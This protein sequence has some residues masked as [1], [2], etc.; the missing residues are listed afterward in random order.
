MIKIARTD[1]NNNPTA[2]TTEAARSL[3]LKEGVD[4]VR[5]DVF[6]DNSNLYTAK[7]LGDPIKTTVKGL[8][9][10]SSTPGVSA[11]R[12]QA[13]QLRWTHTN[14]SNEEWNS[15]D[16]AS[17]ANVVK[18][19]YQKE[20]GDGSLVVLSDF[21]NKVNLSRRKGKTDT[22]ILDYLS[23]QNA[24][25]ADK[26]QRSRA[27]G[28]NDRDITNY[29][30]QSFGG[31]MPTVPSVST[32]PTVT[33]HAPA[34]PA[35]ETFTSNVRTTKEGSTA[36]I[37]EIKQAYDKIKNVRNQY[38]VEA[39]QYDV[40]RKVVEGMFD[41]GEIDR[42]NN[43]I[44]EAAMVKG[45]KSQQESRGVLDRLSRFNN[46]M[47]ET[48]MNVPGIK[49]FK[50][51]TGAAVGGFT[52]LEAAL[53]AAVS[54]PVVNMAQG[55]KFSDKWWQSI[56]DTATK[57]TELG[58]VPMPSA[59]EFG[60]QQGESLATGAV[61]QA[62]TGGLGR[63]SP[64]LGFGAEAGMA[65]GM[66]AGGGTEIGAGI[67]E[68]SPEKIVSGGTSLAFAGMMG[69]GARGRA[70][71]A[72][73]EIGGLGK[74]VADFVSTK[75]TPEQLVSKIIQ[76][77]STTAT[78]KEQHLKVALE[79]F[80][81]TDMTGVRDYGQAKRV[82]Q[83]S[84]NKLMAAKEAYLK[85]DYRVFT[86]QELTKTV[87]K[88]PVN[89][90]EN[91]LDDLAKA[92]RAKADNNGL[93]YIDA[94]RGKLDEGTISA[95]DVER[96]AQVYGT[97]Y[98]KRSFNSATGEPLLSYTGTQFEGT[99]SGLKSTVRELF[100]ESKFLETIDHKIANNITTQKLLDKVES[101]I[102]TAESKAKA[103]DF[104]SKTVGNAAKWGVKAVDAM[105]GHATSKILREIGVN[106]IR[107]GESMS[108][109]DIQKNLKKFLTK[110]DTLNNSKGKT[111]NG[112]LERFLDM[113]VFKSRKAR[114][115]E[116]FQSTQQKLL[117]PAKTVMGKEYRGE[118]NP[119][120]YTPEQ[121]ANIVK[122]GTPERPGGLYEYQQNIKKAQQ[123]A[124]TYKYKNKITVVRH[125]TTD[126]NGDGKLR[127]WKNVPLSEQGKID[128]KKTAK[129]LKDS[130]ITKIV[131]SDLI[132]TEQ[133]AE[134]ISKDT[135]VKVELSAG[136]RPWDVGELAGEDVKKTL[137]ILKEYAIETPDKPIPGGESF[138][139]FKERFLS[140]VEKIKRANPEDRVAIVTHH[141]GDR[142][143]A[144]WETK[145]MPTDHNVDMEEFFK[146][147]IEPSAYRDVNVKP[148]K[149]FPKGSIGYNEGLTLKTFRFLEGK[150][151]I[152]KQYIEDLT[153]RGDIRQAERD[154]IRTQLGLIKG[155]TVDASQFMDAVKRELLPLKRNVQP[156]GMYEDTSLIYEL[157]GKVKDYRE[158]IYESPIKTSAGN[159][160]FGSRDVKQ[161]NYFGHTRTEDMADGKTRR[162]IEVQSDLYQRG[163][164]KKELPQKGRT[165]QELKN[166]YPN[167]FG[168]MT[169]SQ[170]EKEFGKDSNIGKEKLRKIEGVQKLQQYDNP[171]AHFRMVREEV[172]Q[173]AKDGKKALQFPTGETAMKIEG[174][175]EERMFEIVKNG[176]NSGITLSKDNM[177]I[178]MEID[179]MGS[180]LIITDVLRDGKFKAISK[181]AF[182]EYVGSLDKLKEVRDSY[183]NAGYGNLEETFDISGKVDT[184]NPIY[185]FY[186]KDLGRYLKNN[187]GA[188]LITDKQGIKWYQINIKPEHSAPVEA[189]GNVNLSPIFYGLGALSAGTA[190]LTAIE[191][192]K[193]KALE[194]FKSEQQSK[195]DVKS[196][197][198]KELEAELDK[199]SGTKRIYT[200]IGS[201]KRGTATNYDPYDPAQTRPNTN[202]EGAL[203]RKVVFGDVAIGNRIELAVA[204]FNL[205]QGKSI[206][207]EI[208]ELKDIKTPY[209]YGV[210]RVNDSMAI[211][212]NGLNRVDVALPKEHYDLKKRIGKIKI[213][214]K[215]KK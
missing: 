107:R 14:M 156:G 141:R 23:A 163:N 48:L 145:G 10:A 89:H 52:A 181:V 182:D 111:F 189:F 152:S 206:F 74:K 24:G 159:I 17:K 104:W 51:A 97:E 158:N 4:F 164:L 142:I 146:E 71:A 13:G 151:N 175:G 117:P 150:K 100:P 85:T 79:T 46:D 83:D 147:G 50:E 109:L 35:E 115:L 96:L 55:K 128:V 118:P 121:K 58:G 143:L 119:V 21:T 16:E 138:N 127:G 133:T 113:E 134:A 39:A 176:T 40:P 200:S 122:Y 160:H 68:K 57:G 38:I 192:R 105:T 184:N 60:K 154:L 193:R 49:Q 148:P 140:E 91:A 199:R 201:S 11:F 168:G 41:R 102:M 28:K 32:S 106:A 20:G 165:L 37:D 36:T 43:W 44:R 15:L 92:Y 120:P 135:G 25:L 84:S 123:A 2:M 3:G 125:G 59:Y 7:L 194:K 170:Y 137:P 78:K 114:A 190:G 47:M 88:E 188:E 116:R 185:R 26:V 54:Q 12:T 209:G 162:V 8:D 94:I 90:I 19:M 157:R 112:Q 27:L 215:Y 65:A 9:T 208:P 66:A 155:N 18:Q 64:T 29:L 73:R 5:G 179:Q 80:S 198:Q 204:K 212:Y 87:G 171:T 174:L 205:K 153:N 124:G 62:A 196:I 130:G 167:E 195:P 61:L 103:E 86:K 33:P 197:T 56:R 161:K 95:F 191:A 108:F 131:S 210:F 110:L 72:A 98:G 180:N 75:Y 99:R 101:K 187:Y 93:A 76:D 81:R 34:V 207:I 129:E 69:L 132:R 45:V 173:A 177:K 53:V 149:K 166:T 42:L 169:P 63:V 22:Q 30:A 186:E 172:R 77:R 183:K 6:P 178:G 211:R 82:I 67:E 1:R 136:L 70:P 126:L 213:T 144:A 31:A 202:G 214:Y 203:G 139:A